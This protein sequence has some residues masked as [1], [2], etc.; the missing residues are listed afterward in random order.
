MM[1]DTSVQVNERLIWLRH[2]ALSL[3]EHL[4][5]PNIADEDWWR[6]LIKYLEALERW[7]E[8]TRFE[9]IIPE[10]GKSDSTKVS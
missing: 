5:R 2:D 9:Y 7:S 6:K 4:N 8:K 10:E 3:V 1:E